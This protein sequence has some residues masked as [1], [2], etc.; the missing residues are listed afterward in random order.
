MKVGN[1]KEDRWEIGGKVEGKKVG[2]LLEKK[3]TI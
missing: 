1:S 3:R 2:T